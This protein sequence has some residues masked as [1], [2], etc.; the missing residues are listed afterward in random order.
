MIFYFCVVFIRY[1]QRFDAEL[2]QINVKNAIGKR[3]I[4]QNFSREKAIEMTIQAEK[5]EYQTVGIC[6]YPAIALFLFCINLV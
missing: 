3:S 5:N 6:N 4:G 1:F 2:E